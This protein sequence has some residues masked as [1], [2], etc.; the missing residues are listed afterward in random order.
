M[1]LPSNRNPQTEIGTRDLGTA[2]VGCTMFLF[3]GIWNV[4][5]VWIRKVIRHFK[6]GLMGH[7]S[8]SMEESVAE[9]KMN[10][11]C[12][13]QGCSWHKNINMWPRDYSYDILAKNVVAFCP[14]LKSL[15]ETNVKNFELTH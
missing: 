5:R 1:T 13:A 10:C 12:L 8:R 15:P 11:R 6:H 4:L 7:P 3:G 2:V 14:S 9:S